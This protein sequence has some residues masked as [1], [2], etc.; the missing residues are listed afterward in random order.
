MWSTVAWV[1][2]FS[3]GTAILSLALKSF[4]VFTS[5]LRVTSIIGTAAHPATALTPPFMR[6][7]PFSGAGYRRT[8]GPRYT[9]HPGHAHRAAG[10]PPP[11]RATTVR[12]AAF[13]ILHHSRTMSAAGSGADPFGLPRRRTFGRC[14]SCHFP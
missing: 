5:G 6:S 2:T 7:S 14:A 1:D 10:V 13:G 8:I 9:A 3:V 11:R 12:Q 4:S